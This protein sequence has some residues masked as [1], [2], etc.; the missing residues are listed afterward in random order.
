M[1]ENGSATSRGLSRPHPEERACASAST[2]S[3]ARARVSKDEDGHGMALM[4]RDASQRP[5]SVEAP[6]PASC[7][8]APQHE[9]ERSTNLRLYEMTTGE[10]SLFPDC[11]LQRLLQLRRVGRAAH[12]RL[13]KATRAQTCR[14]ERPSHSSR[15]SIDLAQRVVV[16]SSVCWCEC[17]AAKRSAP[18]EF[19]ALFRA[20]AKCSSIHT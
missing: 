18:S 9:G 16:V 12:S 13:G 19:K 3:N 2:K 5:E 10:D 15:S 6:A 20:T 4:L 14:V 1:T 17:C 7:C 11:Y 8:D